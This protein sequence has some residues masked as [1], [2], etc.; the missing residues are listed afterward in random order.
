MRRVGWY[1]IGFAIALGVFG[2]FLP[3]TAKSAQ[4]GIPL[5]PVA[6]VAHPPI[7][8]MSG[9]ARS[10]TY[11]DTYWVH[12]DSGD[13]ARIFAIRLDGSVIVP[14]FVSRRDSSTRPEEPPVIFEGILI[15]GASNIDWED[16][17]MDGDTLYIADMG[18]NGNARRD[19]AVYVLKEPNP[20]E[21]TRTHI[22]QRIPVAYPDQNGFP[23]SDRWHFDCE[24]VF[25]MD[26]KLYCLTKHRKQGS[27]NTPETGTN[28]YRL[29]TTHS[30][31]VNILTKV[32]SH[33]DLG[34][35]ATAASLSPDGRTLAVLCQAPQQSV[36]L[37]ERPPQ[38]D[39]FLSEGKA[40]QIRF[41]NGKQCEAI[42]WIDDHRLVITNE[43]REIFILDTRK[44]KIG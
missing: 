37:F 28:L 10:R 23:P 8:E 38:G 18:N 25:V 43:Q 7:D 19:L 1:L 33:P 36:W 22:L 40:R 30:D 29:D 16:I 17:A 5:Q 9:I 26:G 2:W 20:N 15:E 27:L 21:T 6:T 44:K 42:E 4:N 34:G 35:W 12:N 24:A 41:R 13:R 11:P 14:L 39:R 32:D 31:K 3:T